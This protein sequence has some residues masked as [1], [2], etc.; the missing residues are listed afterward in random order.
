MSFLLRCLSWPGGFA[1]CICRWPA[2]VLRAAP[3]SIV[4]VLAVLVHVPGAAAGPALLLDEAS[5]EVL[6]AEQ[7]DQNWYPASL[8][9]LMTAYV[10]FEALR[11][12]QITLQ[13]VVPLSE[14]ARAQPATRIGLKAGIELNVDQALRGLILRSANDFAMAL[15]ELVGSSEEGFAEKMNASAK[16]LGMSRS[17]FVNPHGLPEAAQFTTARD[18]AILAR[19]IRKDF[20]ERGEIFTTANFVIYRGT[21]HNQNDL[22]R[23]FE[24]ADGMKTGF[25]CGAGYNVVASA[26]RDGRRLIAV[27]LG[28][29]TKDDRSVRA[30]GLLEHGFKT[31]DWKKMLGVGD[32]ARLDME[33]AEVLPVHDMSRETRA[34]QCGNP[35][36]RVRLIVAQNRPAAVAGPIVTGSTP[37]TQTGSRSVTVTQPKAVRPAA[38][39]ALPAVPA[40]ANGGHG[41]GG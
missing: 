15:A 2:A 33:P 38:S 22:L 37:V 23:T 21:F 16:R 9:K 27:V 20:P 18:L 24:G 30:A 6:Y 4:A 17:H 1:R 8:T 13:T 3:A 26:T 5:G 31:A 36:R 41:S 29:A 40:P 28:E 7:P 14:K 25:T 35:V 39:K 11:A 34:R 10:T 32:L 12:G 19:A